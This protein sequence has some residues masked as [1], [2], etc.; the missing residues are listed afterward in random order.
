M[1]TDVKEKY[2]ALSWR[3][4]HSIRYHGRRESFFMTCHRMTMFFVAASGLCIMVSG[5]MTQPQLALVP[6]LGAAVMLLCAFDVTMKLSTRVALHGELKRRFVYVAALAGMYNDD[7]ARMDSFMRE[8]CKIEADRP[9]VLNVL[10]NICY[11]EM[12]ADER[13]FDAMVPMS[14]MQYLCA[15]FFDWR[16]GTLISGA[17][18]G[19]TARKPG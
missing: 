3:V 2:E 18:I 11:N 9:R 19:G 6:F 14:S 17:A 12:V 7:S 16:P 1:D 5:A 15:D 10:N 8:V 4:R 13:R